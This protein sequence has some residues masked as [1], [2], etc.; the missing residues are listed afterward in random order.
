MKKKL[1]FALV[2]GMITFTTLGYF[3]LAAENREDVEQPKV[4]Y[5]LISSQQLSYMNSLL[6]QSIKRLFPNARETYLEYNSEQAGQY[7]K[8][9]DIRFVPFVIYSDSIETTESFAH[10]QHHNMVASVKGYYVI[11]EAQLKM[12]EIMLLGEDRPIL[13]PVPIEFFYSESCRPCQ[14]I[15]NAFLPQ[16]ESE[17]KDKIAI[18]YHNIADA[19]EIQLK[20]KMEQQYG[21]TREVIPELFLPGKALVGSNAIRADL[22]A[23]IKETLKQRGEVAAEK[24]VAG[25]NPFLNKFA[26]FSPVVV[27]LAGLVDGINPCAFATMVFFVSFLALNRYRKEQIAYIGSAFIVGVFLTYLGLG[28]GI[29]QVLKKLQAFSLL[30]HIIYYAIALLALG[31]GIYS[32]CD[33]ITYKRTGQTRGCSLKLYNRLRSLAESRRALL[34]LIIIAFVNGFIIALLESACTGQVYFP[35]IAFVLKVP[36]LRLHALLYLILY[37]LAFIVPLVAI[38]LLACKGLASEK[39][40]LFEQRHLGAIKLAFTILFFSLAILL[41]LM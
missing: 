13:W 33:Y 2:A 30:S 32:L 23:L 7:I 37:N 20:M 28:L 15:K 39:F 9:L 27:L 21:V 18:N 35:T 25:E 19:E 34:I 8:E 10:M 4:D 24:A 31:L 38:F 5:I 1:L 26:T 17:F 11:P 16:I 29:F 12:G 22:A 3:A 36:S 6:R 41:F 14:G 40:S